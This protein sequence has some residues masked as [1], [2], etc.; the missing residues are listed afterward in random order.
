MEDSTRYAN[1]IIGFDDDERDYGIAVRMLQLL[2]CTRVR[3]MT[4]NPSKID[5]LSRAGIDVSGR[6]PLHGPNNADNLR[7]LAARRPA[8]DT[9]LI[10]CS[11]RLLSPAGFRRGDGEHPN[12][13]IFVHCRAWG[14]E[15]MPVE[16]VLNQAA[17]ERSPSASRRRALTMYWPD[18]QGH[19]RTARRI[20]RHI[21]LRW[22]APL[23]DR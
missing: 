4:N 7:Y 20:T 19:T 16:P 5:G 14:T 23:R 15:R 12:D 18:Q 8:L 3:L 13:L 1:S 17:M 2:G 21:I 6:V 11:A 22:A 10:M 9:S